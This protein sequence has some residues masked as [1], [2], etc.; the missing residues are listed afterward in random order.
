[1]DARNI[2]LGS[3]LMTSRLS[4]LR[5]SSSHCARIALSTVSPPESKTVHGIFQEAGNE[6]FVRAKDAFA[7]SITVSSDTSLRSHMSPDL[8][9]MFV[10]RVNNAQVPADDHVLISLICD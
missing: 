3:L 9:Q 4:G 5:L 6:A 1:M 7:I 8:L 2:E 10:Q